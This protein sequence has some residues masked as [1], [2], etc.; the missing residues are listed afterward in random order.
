MDKSILSLII[1]GVALVMVHVPHVGL[2]LGIIGGLSIVA[3]KL[4]WMVIQEFSQSTPQSQR[5][6]PSPSLIPQRQSL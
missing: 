6:S 1:A 4:I 2:T 3:I 5:R